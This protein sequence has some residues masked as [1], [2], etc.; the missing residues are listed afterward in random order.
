MK[1]VL[2]ADGIQLEFGLRKILSDVYI[3]CE[4]GTI[5]GLLGRNGSGKSCLMNIIYGVLR[6][7]DKSI[8][9]DHH[10]ISIPYSK[11]GLIKFLPQH[12]FVPKSLSVKRIFLDF[13]L[14]WKDFEER[15]S[16][17]SIHNTHR[18]MDL[19]GGQRR[20]IEVYIILASHAQFVLLD[21]PFTHIMP[22]DIEKIKKMMLEE[23]YRKGIFLTDHM[24]KHI[25]D[26]SDHLYL[27]KDGKTWLT[28]S[29]SDLETHGYALM[30]KR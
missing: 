7:N 15:F 22:L 9:F 17:S 1:H 10:K 16:E 2:E 23:K 4:T 12:H 8:R 26:L 3:S 21:E 30:E 29:S 11:P 20:L 13:G 5:T 24:Y 6:C 18:M 19:S 28:R 27:L 25:V 14:D